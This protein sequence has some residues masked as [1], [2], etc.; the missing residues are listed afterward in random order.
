M[1]NHLHVLW[2]HWFDH[3]FCAINIIR[4]HFVHINLAVNTTYRQFPHI[5]T[6]SKGKKFQIIILNLLQF[7]YQKHLGNLIFLGML[8][9]K[10]LKKRNLKR[11]LTWI[12]DLIFLHS[13][14]KICTLHNGRRGC[15][16]CHWYWRKHH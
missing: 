13:K 10:F 8:Q 6:N 9:F 12:K 3:R 2:F 5:P 1:L 11:N 15:T 7:N 4:F 16:G 14:L